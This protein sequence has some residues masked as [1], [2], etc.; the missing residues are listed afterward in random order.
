MSG[1]YQAWGGIVFTLGITLSSSCAND[2]KSIRLANVDLSDSSVVH[3]LGQGLRGA[4]RAA[5]S[6]YVFRHRVQSAG[7]CGKKLV[8]HE[9][10]GPTTIGEA[11]DL[12]IAR[13]DADARR[14]AQKPVWAQRW[15]ELTR[16]RDRL[17]DRQGFLLA[18][19]GSAA[20]Q[21][22]D[23]ETL[24]ASLTENGRALTNLRRVSGA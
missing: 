9:G 1:L 6:T 19:H 13:Q 18:E 5:L 21:T 20:R 11:I 22:L 23:W 17:I 7:F 14:E 8:D 12:T 4:E 15:E 24:E 16:E 10:G 3:K 2:V